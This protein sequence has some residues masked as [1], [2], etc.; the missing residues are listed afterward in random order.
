M[1]DPAGSLAFRTHPTTG[2]TREDGRSVSFFRNQRNGMKRSLGYGNLDALTA[3]IGAL[4]N[5][6][7]SAVTLPR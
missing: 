4:R 5:V 1:F 7:L 2:I 6:K 3:I